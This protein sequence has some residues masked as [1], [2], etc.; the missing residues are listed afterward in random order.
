MKITKKRF[1][2]AILCILLSVSFVIS[3]N[4]VPA[5]REGGAEVGIPTETP[6]DLSEKQ[7]TV[8]EVKLGNAGSET[9]VIWSSAATENVSMIYNRFDSYKMTTGYEDR[10]LTEVKLAES[11]AKR[12]KLLAGGKELP[13]VVDPRRSGDIAECYA[14]PKKALIE[15]GWEAKLGI[16]EMCASSWKWQSTNPNG[17]KS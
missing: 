4:T 9:M 7:S 17:Y 1:F 11:L 10:V 6:A 15:M 13:Y 16:E 3:C 5:E 12:M 14:D 2:T 8:K